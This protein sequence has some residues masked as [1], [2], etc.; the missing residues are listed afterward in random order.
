MRRNIVQD[1]VASPD[2]AL[3]TQTGEPV[4]LIVDARGVRK[5]Y[6]S[7]CVVDSISLQIREGEFCGILGPNGA[8]KT[9]TLRILTGLASADSGD[10]RVLGFPVPACAR[11]MRAKIGIVPQNDNLDPDL[12]VVE[13]L[14]V[15]GRY[16]G[17]GGGTLDH[18]VRDLLQFSSLEERANSRI[19]ELS[20]GMRR[21]LTIARALLNS[22]RLL[23]L[24]EPTTGLDP[25]ARHTV[26]E[27][28]RLLH[29]NGLTLI[30]CTHYMEEAERLCDRIVVMDHGRVLADQSPRDLVASR[31]EP[32]VVEVHGIELTE[33]V[34]S[35]A[36]GNGIRVERVGETVFF[37]GEDLQ[38]L[39]EKLDRGYAMRYLYRQAN[40]EDVFLKL[41]GRDLR[42]V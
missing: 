26:W 15:Y 4:P 30:L 19:S 8:G 23:I 38:P 1:P 35:F 6:A 40:L 11:Q 31:I 42:D 13:N 28:L 10:L 36:P 32:H 2:S 17:L 16:F 24:D 37:Y 22:P 7:R 33:L 3:A 12:S 18:R 20:G 27:Q 5:S 21:R 41:T 39:V 34:K 14:Q 25:Q 9:T 29:R